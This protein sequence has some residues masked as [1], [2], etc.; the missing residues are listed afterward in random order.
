MFCSVTAEQVEEVAILNQYLD[1][2]LLL[3]EGV[4]ELV[5]EYSEREK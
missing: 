3:W 4:K 1:V 2:W 5:S